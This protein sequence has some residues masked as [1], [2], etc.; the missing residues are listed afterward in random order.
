MRQNVLAFNILHN[1]IKD[2]PL[3][4][5]RF[6]NIRATIEWISLYEHCRHIYIASQLSRSSK[7]FVFFFFLFSVFSSM[8]L[9]CIEWTRG[10]SLYIIRQTFG[11]RFLYL[12]KS[13]CGILCA[14]FFGI[15]FAFI[16]NNSEFMF[17]FVNMQS[18]VIDA[19]AIY[20]SFHFSSA[21]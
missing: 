11:I 10:I 9:L 1:F 20:F 16:S 3:K 7:K 2:M 17:E 5:I 15:F 21:Y 4:N 19:F 8:I 14:A 18:N 6:E 13:I 12:I